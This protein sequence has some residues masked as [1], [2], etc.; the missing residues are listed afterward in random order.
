MAATP[1]VLLV[2]TSHAT[3]GATGRKTGYWLAEVTH[4]HQAVS[5]GGFGVDIASPQGGLPPLDEKSR[6]PRDATNQ[7]FLEDVRLRQKLEQ[8]LAV[9]AV[10]AAAYRALYFAGGHGAMWDFPDNAHLAAIAG[11]I[12]RRGGVV[13][14]VCHG[15]A[16]L[17]GL[18]DEAG[19]PL[20]RGR[21]VTGFSN[22]EERLLG[23][24]RAVPFLLEDRL[25]AT[26]GLYRRAF[27][28]FL[29]YLEEDGRLVTGQNPASA[30]AV[31]LRVAAL[32][33]A[34][35]PA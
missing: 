20:L 28:P 10:D 35:T 31:G 24:T 6:S 19:A 4:F 11:D 16:G 3:L 17:L 34:G 1:S 32:L 7:T 2:V 18:R 5:A 25:R 30:R 9:A 13:S 14:A 27:L 23:L 21:R 33:A 26:G 22:L 29:P 15:S 8:S 12:Y